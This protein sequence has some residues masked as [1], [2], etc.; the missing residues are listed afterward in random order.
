[1]T[2]RCSRPA[3]PR[4]RCSA[5]CHPEPTWQALLRDLYAEQVLGLYV[6]ED[7]ALYVRRSGTDPAAIS[8]YQRVTAAH[9]LTHALQDQHWGL[10][11]LR[12]LPDDAVDADSAALALIEGDAV[13]LQ[14]RWQELHQS[15]QDQQ[16]ATAEVAANPSVVL[17]AAPRALQDALLFPYVAGADFARAVLRDGG[18][19]ALDAAFDDPPSTTEQ[20]LH[21]IAYTVRDTPVAALPAGA[22]PEGWAARPGRGVR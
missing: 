18:R 6:P 15:A 1:M 19:E 8:A 10:Q 2:P 4:S 16:A 3:P 17:D 14:E 22:P 5:S 7:Q 20:V 13:V 11:A 21:P 9:E 12:D